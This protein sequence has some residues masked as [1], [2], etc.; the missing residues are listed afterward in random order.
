MM[1]SN[2]IEHLSGWI[3][4]HRR[5]FEAGGVSLIVEHAAEDRP[6]ASIRVQLEY[7]D[8][9]GEVIVWENGMVDLQLADV[10]TGNVDTVSELISSVGKLQNVEDRLLSWINFNLE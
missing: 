8:R 4:L 3:K 7:G 6:I 10:I 5:V 9:L 2:L 1:A